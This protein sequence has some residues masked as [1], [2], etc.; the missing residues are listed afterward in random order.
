MIVVFFANSVFKYTKTF[1]AHS[2]WQTVLN[3]TLQRECRKS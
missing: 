1:Q 2:T 3:V